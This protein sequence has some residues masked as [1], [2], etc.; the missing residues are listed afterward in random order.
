[1]RPQNNIFD[2]KIYLLTISGELQN[3]AYISLK[4][5]CES[6][7]V[8]YRMAWNGK[9]A[10]KGVI[11]TDAKVIAAKSKRRH[12]QDEYSSNFKRYKEDSSMDE[13]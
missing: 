9:R 2:M 12:A 13:A 1:M 10:W 4:D 7:N 5:A 11:I 6:A 3:E 8:S